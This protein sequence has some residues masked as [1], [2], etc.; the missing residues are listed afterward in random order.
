MTYIQQNTGNLQ[1]FCP[2]TAPQLHRE[3]I[4][5][6][7]MRLKLKNK[8]LAILPEIYES[9]IWKKYA[10]TI[11]EYA[12]KFG[13]IAGTTVKKRLRLE[14]NLS[15]KPC[16]KAAIETVGVHKVA[17]VAKITTPEMDEV[18]ADKLCHMSKMAVQTLSKELRDGRQ[19]SFGDAGNGE[20]GGVET[21][22]KAIALTKKIEL[23]EQSTFL[24]LKLKEKLGKHLSDKEFLKL[25][26]EDR[27]K[28]EF[29]RKASKIEKSIVSQGAEKSVIGETFVVTQSRYIP[30]TR[31]RQVLATT[32]GKCTY[33]NCNSPY[34]VLHHVD[35][36]SESK[37]HDSIIP[38]CK[39]H[40]EFAHNNLIKN[41][42]GSA[43]EWK[44]AVRQETTTKIS[45]ADILYRKYRK[46]SIISA[47]IIARTDEVKVYDG[48]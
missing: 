29:T 18:M 32:N 34:A 13:E 5:L 20:C 12:G 43:G 45:Q 31:K 33:P 41:E 24:F 37:N 10:G 7:S 25:I 44:L 27:E 30:A 16:L 22:C 14:E 48:G 40:H 23:D 15:N 36:Y 39:V 1:N 28:Q 17:M 21:L 2:M 42:V 38:L 4:R 35:R 6:G 3:F 26:I 47:E 46:E 8:M 11:E 19:L 9:G